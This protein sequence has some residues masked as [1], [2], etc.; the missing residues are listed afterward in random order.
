MINQKLSLGKAFQES[1]HRIDNWIDEESGWIVEL[2]KF[3]YTMDHYQDVL[4]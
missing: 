3:Q 1:L 2:F 4:M